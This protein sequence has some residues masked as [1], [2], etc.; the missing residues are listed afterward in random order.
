MMKKHHIWVFN[1]LYCFV[2]AFVLHC[3]KYAFQW[4]P[5]SLSSLGFYVSREMFSMFGAQHSSCWRYLILL[6]QCSSALCNFIN[7]QSAR[8]GLLSLYNGTFSIKEKWALLFCHLHIDV[9]PLLPEK[10]KSLQ[11]LLFF[12]I[13]LKMYIFMSAHFWHPNG[14]LLEDLAI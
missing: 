2:F 13:L 11:T 1:T 3:S 6:K 7:S 8:V 12:N 4:I 14:V 5:L 10:I 9:T